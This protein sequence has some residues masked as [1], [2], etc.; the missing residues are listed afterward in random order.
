MKLLAVLSLGAGS[1]FAQGSAAFV[2]AGF[3]AI[4]P[5]SVA[6]GQVITIFA[7]GVGNVT[8]K[9]TSAKPPLANTLAGITAVL[10][11]G[12]TPIPSPILAVFPLNDCQFTLP[13]VKCG[14]VRAVT[15][16]IPFERHPHIPG[17]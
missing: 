9:T 10:V 12:D 16:Q 2:G 6:P 5:V 7:T 11:R 17:S 15:V 8:Q 4:A 3:N 14:S 1:V 13:A